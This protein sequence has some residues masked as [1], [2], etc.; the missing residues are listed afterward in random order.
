MK[1]IAFI[2]PYFGKLPNHIQLW[3]NSCEKNKNN[4]YFLIT[5]DD[6]RNYYIPSNVKV[7][8]QSFDEFKK[9]VQ[10][11][12]D[13][14]ISLNDV[15]KIVDY[16]PALGYIY[17]E[18]IE[19]YRAW[20][21]VDVADEIYGNINK[22]ITREIIDNYDKIMLLG[23]M[24]VY[25]NSKNNNRRFMEASNASFGYRDVYSNPKF[26]N[27]EEVAVGSIAR[28]YRD[29]SYP[30][31]QLEESFAD[32]SCLNFRFKR[33][34]CKPNFRFYYTNDSK[35]PSIYSWEDGQVFGYFLQKHNI[36]KKEFAYVH[37]KRRKMDIKVSLDSK[38]FLIVPN[39]FIPF[40]EVD[41]NMIRLYGKDRLNYSIKRKTKDLKDR[42]I[43]KLVK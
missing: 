14:K 7:I 21:N 20:G 42:V 19:D 11:K 24:S 36:V 27:F 32:I 31:K 39:A 37:F 38:K 15:S 1:E 8:S 4:V 29:N 9:N 17:E 43:N 30:L 26:Y 16:K 23:H 35:Y 41:K 33:K 28:I 13:F 2:C 25:K 34:Y 22:F 5:D 6:V 10:K 40:K 12:F 3:L 18:L